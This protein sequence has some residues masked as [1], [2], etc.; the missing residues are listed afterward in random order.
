MEETIISIKDYAKSRNRTVQG[1]YQQ[2][3]RKNNAELLKEHI[4]TKE[5]GNRKVKFEYNVYKIILFTTT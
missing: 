1:V 2:I 5:V 4:I 3:S